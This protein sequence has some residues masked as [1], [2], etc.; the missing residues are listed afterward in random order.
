[1]RDLIEY[2]RHPVAD[3]I[4]EQMMRSVNGQLDPYQQ[5]Y[6]RPRD[7]SPQSNKQSHYEQYPMIDQSVYPWP[8]Q[9]IKKREL[10]E[11]RENYLIFIN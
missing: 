8:H 1:V 2:S 5:I 11:F 6:A 3:I 7:G 4:P 9:V 10:R